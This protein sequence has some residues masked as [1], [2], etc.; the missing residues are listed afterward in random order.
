M[1]IV[2]KTQKRYEKTDCDFIREREKV[3]H[4]LHET[5]KDIKWDVGCRTFHEIPC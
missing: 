3:I 4:I 5:M 1:E 2:G